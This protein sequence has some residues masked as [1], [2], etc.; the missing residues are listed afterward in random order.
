[1]WCTLHFLIQNVQWRREFSSKVRL[2]RMRGPPLDDLFFLFYLQNAM[3][4]YFFHIVLFITT[5]QC[6]LTRV[7]GTCPNIDGNDRKWH[8]AVYE[9]KEIGT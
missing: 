3:H 2:C 8:Y 9:R 6:S 1:M 7:E 4:L 5:H